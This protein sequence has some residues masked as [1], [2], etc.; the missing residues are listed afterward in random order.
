MFL[1]Y[2]SLLLYI[3]IELMEYHFDIHW[4]I[5]LVGLKVLVEQLYYK[6][7]KDFELQAAET[8]IKLKQN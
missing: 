2:I 7:C 3:S 6:I 5:I 4:L 8:Q 1:L